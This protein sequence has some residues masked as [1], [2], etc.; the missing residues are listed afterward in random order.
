MH[1]VITSLA[2]RQLRQLT[3]SLGLASIIPQPRHSLAGMWSQGIGAPKRKISPI[4][5]NDEFHMTSYRTPPFV[6]ADQWA[7]SIR[8]QVNNPFTFTYPQF[9]TQ[10]TTSEIVAVECAGNGVAGEAIST[11]EWEGVRLKAYWNK[12]EPGPRPM[13]WFFMR[14]TDT[15]I[16]YPSHAP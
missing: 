12:P 5:P 15:Q 13:T 7:L 6:P 2:R 1:Q 8:G 14:P 4:T 10:P 3:A 16:A 11:A 9:L